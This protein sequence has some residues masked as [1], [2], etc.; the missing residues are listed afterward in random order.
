VRPDLGDHCLVVQG[1]RSVT[2]LV[3]RFQLGPHAAWSAEAKRWMPYGQ[4]FSY[5]E[6]GPLVPGEDQELPTPLD[7]VQTSATARRRTPVGDP[8]HRRMYT[9]TNPSGF[10]T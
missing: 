8:R 6:R 5:A 7:R 10:D 2:A 1:P 9:W 4:R 3:R